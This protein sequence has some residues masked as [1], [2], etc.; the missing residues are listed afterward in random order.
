MNFKILNR[1]LFVFLLLIFFH[2]KNQ[3]QEIWTLEMCLQ[4]AM[5]QNL[6]V[7]T[8]QNN[9]QQIQEKIKEVKGGLMPQIS[10]EY[11]YAYNPNIPPTFLPGFIVG[12][13]QQENVAAVLGLKQ[14]QYFRVQASLQL[15]NPQL[16]IALK[17]AKVATQLSELQISKAKE[18]IAYNISATYYNLL[19]LYQQMELLKT[20]IKSFETTIRTTE[21]LQ[22]NDLAKKSDVNRLILQKK[23]LENQLLNIAV[24]ENTL[25][26]VLRVL[27][28]TNENVVFGIDKNVGESVENF[29]EMDSTQIYKRLDFQLLDRQMMLKDLE[30]KTIYSQFMPNLTAIGAYNSYAYYK[31]FNPIERADNKSFPVS[32]VG[33]S[34]TI[35]VYDGGQK[36]SKLRQNKIEMA[37]LTIQ[38]QQQTTQIKSE[39]DNAKKKYATSLV[40]LQLQT[41]NINLAKTTLNETKTNYQN[42]LVSINDIINAENDLQKTQIDYLTALVNVRIAVLD[43]KKNYGTLFKN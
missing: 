26:N 20:N 17:V 14:T 9:A 10:A 13:P 12:Q 22:K 1:L 42:G 3:A 24:T 15:F 32:L 23:N 27:T 5:T 34:L 7:K 35:P 31:D 2:Q 4:K 33:L 19:T 29:V 16:L 30:K 38:K 11:N 36:M 21:T 40:S 6:Q 28:N 8:L 41:D 25:L 43:L 18:D 39:L 37:N